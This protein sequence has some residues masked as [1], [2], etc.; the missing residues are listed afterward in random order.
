MNF[1]ATSRI[2]IGLLLFGCIL[3]SSVYFTDLM[4]LYNEKRLFQVGS[5]I[6]GGVLTVFASLD[7]V[8]SWIYFLPRFFWWGFLITFFFTMYSIVSSNYPYYAA[9]ELSLYVLSFILILMVAWL[10]NEDPISIWGIFIGASLLI[11]LYAVKFGLGY[12]FY[13]SGFQ[14][15]PLWPGGG[16]DYTLTGFSNIRFFNQIQVFTLPLI[17]GGTIIKA[18]KEK[19]S[20]L[21]LFFL[22][23]IWW[24][25]LI[26]S[27]GRG[28]ILSTLTTALLVLIFF[29]KETH[30][31][32]W[33]L[34][35]TLAVGYLAKVVLFE[36]IPDPDQ[37][38]SIVRGGSGRLKLWPKLFLDTLDQP[39]LGHGPMMFADIN[40][41]YYR[42]HPHNSVLQLLYELGYP[43]T[44]IIVG[45]TL[46]GIKQWIQQTKR[47]IQE[48][49]VTRD[50]VI[51]KISLTAALFGGLIYSLFSGVI[52]M[53]L[54]QLWLAIVA[55]S[56]LG[57]YI[58]DGVVKPE[59]N[60]KISKIG[61]YGMKLAVL[62][63][64]GV[65]ITVLVKDVPE[66]RKNKQRYIQ[67][68]DTNT[69][70]PRFWQQGKIGLEKFSKNEEIQGSSNL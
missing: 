65:M 25:L 7:T 33:Y 53:P 63:A 46:Y 34:L 70:R 59:N 2:Y 13:V 66:L 45:G 57:I 64:A 10:I 31:W 24:M 27:A 35:G 9:V 17:I 60:I 14:N 37:V 28:I 32:M 48:K 54:S 62:I 20:G 12:T 42:G 47:L 16:F 30:R 15:F 36:V 23:V 50:D 41:G 56:I 6:I 49:K 51:I 4:F 61:L 11:F 69:L 26:Q 44:I 18:R 38:K 55:G 39:T 29:K 52:V 19:Y 67:V 1:K 40:T 58:R 3:L 68:I 43:V 21:F 5:L 8:K 22:A